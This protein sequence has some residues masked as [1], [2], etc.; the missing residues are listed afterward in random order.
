MKTPKADTRGLRRERR[1]SLGTPSSLT[2]A[3]FLAPALILYSVFVLYPYGRAFYLSLTRWR[4]LSESP[5]FIGLGNFRELFD[6]P[7]FWEATRNNLTYVVVVPTLTVALGVGLA[8]LL[9]Q[10]NVPWRRAYRVGF[11]FPQ[12]MSII[13]VGVL[14]RFVY[15]PRLGLLNGVRDV[16]G[17]DDAKAWLGNPDYALWAIAAVIIWQGVGFHMVIFM[18]AMAAIPEEM[19]EAATIDGAQQRHKFW[20]VTL[21]MIR[22]ALV[23][24]TVFLLVT[25]ADMFAITQ[26][27]TDG[28][29]NRATE[30]L[31]TYVLERAFVS[32]RF[33]YASAVSVML[34]LFTIGAVLL[35]SVVL[36]RE[37]K[38]SSEWGG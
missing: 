30:V 33:G 37:R 27:M 12:I 10:A 17:F 29:P 24:S 4:G 18:A 13:A 26:I 11:F 22:D 25:A 19:Y 32:S 16:V 35:I 38:A 20:Y 1:G 9:T 2:V 28:G 15:H 21:P 36:R 6:D 8:F 31:P 7:V 3:A 34:F 23:T 14:W 5:E